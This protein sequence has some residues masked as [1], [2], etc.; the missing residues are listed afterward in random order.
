MFGSSND[1]NSEKA[2]DQ[3]SIKNIDLQKSEQTSNVGSAV[4]LEYKDEIELNQAFNMF[5]D[6]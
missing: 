5:K 1:G 4:N 2:E 3:D 6:V